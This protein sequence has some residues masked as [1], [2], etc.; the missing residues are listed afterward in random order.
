M[1]NTNTNFFEIFDFQK[2]LSAAKMPSLDVNSEALINS[3][4]KTMEAFA[5]ASKAAF[6]GVNAFSKKQVEILNDAIASAKD[7]TS[8]I[9][10]G[11]VQESVA[12]S[13]DSLKSAIIEAQANVAELA[14]I[15]EK[16]A[17][18]AF[19]ILNARF[20]DGLTEIK[21]VIIDKKTATAS[22]KN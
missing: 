15:N 6:E 12:K 8:E 3:Q 10:K 21:N 14:K 1:F 4:K 17:K 19:D 5:G 18:E 20:L 16:T 13:V 11:N 7:V 2:I 9:A 22:V